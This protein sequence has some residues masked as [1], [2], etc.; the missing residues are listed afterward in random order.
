MG[1]FMVL[2]FRLCSPFDGVGNEG[3]GKSKKRFSSEE[4]RLNQFF[5]PRLLGE[6]K[7][8]PKKIF[9]ILI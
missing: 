2:C 6:E 8:A 5:R 3:H 1:R 9:P 7:R 4:R